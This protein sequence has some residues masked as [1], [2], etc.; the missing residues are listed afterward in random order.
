MVLGGFGSV[1]GALNEFQKGFMS[2]LGDFFVVSE[3]LGQ[4]Q[5]KPIT[6]INLNFRR[7]VGFSEALGVFWRVKKGPRYDTRGSCISG[8]FRGN[9]GAFSGIRVSGLLH[10]RGFRRISVYFRGF[11]GLMCATGGPELFQGIFGGI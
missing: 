4:S 9:T 7:Q 8:S 1:S 3:A 2:V 5:T 6:K 11:K 10:G